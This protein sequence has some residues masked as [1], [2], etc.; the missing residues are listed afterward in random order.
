MLCLLATLLPKHYDSDQVA[1]Y[2]SVQRQ[3]ERSGPPGEWVI[4]GWREGNGGKGEEK[5]RKEGEREVE[6][7]LG[8]E[9][10]EMGWAHFDKNKMC[11]AW[12]SNVFLG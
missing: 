5:K 6:E 8:R 7:R 12:D 11:G 2:I 1:C 9:G 3:S 10:G 4:I